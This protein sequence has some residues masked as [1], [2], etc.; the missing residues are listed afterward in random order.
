MCQAVMKRALEIGD[1]ADLRRGESDL[2]ESDRGGRDT[3]E[4]ALVHARMVTA[5][6]RDAKPSIIDTCV[7]FS[8][9]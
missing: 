8:R 4:R 3:V 1:T 6:L 9:W 7:E 5:R 2:A